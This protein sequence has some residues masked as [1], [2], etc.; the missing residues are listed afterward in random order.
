MALS[1]SIASCVSGILDVWSFFIHRTRWSS[2]V[3]GRTSRVSCP[4]WIPP[5]CP[6]ECSKPATLD[7]LFGFSSGVYLD[8]M[9]VQQTER[10]PRKAS[11]F[12]NQI[13]EYRLKVGI[14][15]RELGKRVGYCR[16]VISA[17]ERGNILPSLPNVFRLAKALDTLV[18]S[19]Y[20]TLYSRVSRAVAKDNSE[21]R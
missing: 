18:E 16:S 9:T 6:Q 2:A 12:P 8:S 15:Q 5:I 11:R 13:R 10:I 1:S 21:R 17:W 14:S 4:L 19:L 20:L 7:P 3:W